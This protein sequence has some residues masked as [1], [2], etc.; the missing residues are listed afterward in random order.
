MNS[1][2]FCFAIARIEAGIMC[3]KNFAVRAVAG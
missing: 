3:D 2:A 1:Y